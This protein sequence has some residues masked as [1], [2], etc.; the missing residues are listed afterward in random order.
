MALYEQDVDPY[1]ITKHPGPMYPYRRLNFES[2]FIVL[3]GLLDSSLRMTGLDVETKYTSVAEGAGFCE[4]QVDVN[5]DTEGVYH[6]TDHGQ[7]ENDPSKVSSSLL[8]GSRTLYG[9][10][11]DEG[12]D[13]TGRSSEVY[14]VGTMGQEVESTMVASES[15]GPGQ[16]DTPNTPLMMLTLL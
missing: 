5:F 13:R 9:M 10:L 16:P 11:T 1:A 2:P 6:T 4:I 3:G 8:R 12:R 15:L 14:V 7:F